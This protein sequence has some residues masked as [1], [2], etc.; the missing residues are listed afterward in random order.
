MKHPVEEL[1]DDKIIVRKI[2]TK[3]PKLFQIAELESQRA[4]KTGM[5]VGSLRERVL[6]AL[7]IHKFGEQN[8]NT[9][10]PITET[11]TDVII[12]GYPLSIKTKTGKSLSGIKSIW[13]VDHESVLSYINNYVPKMGIL[14]VQ[15]LW[16]DEGG[17]YFFPLEVQQNV[18]NE[19]GK[20]DYF[21]IPKI[22]T[23]PRGVEFSPKAISMMIEDKRTRLVKINWTKTEISYNP[24]NRWVELWAQE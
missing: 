21:N 14:L 13:T 12:K 24:F 19:L 16:D 9:E 22:G 11:E 10:I 2:Q 3:L 15:I 18:F 4:G 23:N 5:E 20:N 6:I 1:F 7:F 8:V 17:L